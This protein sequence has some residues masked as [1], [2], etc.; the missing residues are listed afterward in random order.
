[1][2]EGPE[3]DSLLMIV[4]IMEIVHNIPEAL[5][6]PRHW[7]QKSFEA[8][9]RYFDE[10][11]G[12]GSRLKRVYQEALEPKKQCREP[13]DADNPVNSPGNAKSHTDD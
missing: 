11:H 1:M 3:K 5:V 12:I 2:E 7:S 13:N 8:S 6:N 4:Q 10:P 9:L